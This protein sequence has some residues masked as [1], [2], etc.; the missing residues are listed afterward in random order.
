MKASH[1]IKTLISVG[2]MLCA[3]TGCAKFGEDSQSADIGIDES[4][5]ISEE[6]DPEVIYDLQEEDP[7]RFYETEI[8]SKVEVVKTYKTLDKNHSE[9]M[10]GIDN[11]CIYLETTTPGGPVSIFSVDRTDYSTREKILTY[12]WQYMI[13]ENCPAICG[14]YLVFPLGGSGGGNTFWAH[15]GKNGEEGKCILIKYASEFD[16]A[17]SAELSDTEPVFMCKH[18]EKTD[19][20]IYKYKI[21]DDLAQPIYSE[22][23]SERADDSVPLIA[24]CGGQIYLIYRSDDMTVQIKILDPDG[25]LAGVDTVQLPVSPE[26]Q[27]WNFFVTENHYLIN[28]TSAY[29]YGAVNKNVMVDRKTGKIYSNFGEEGIGT[30]LNNALIDGRYIITVKSTFKYDYPI[31]YVFDDLTGEFHVMKFLD[32]SGKKINRAYA[33]C[34]GDVMFWINEED[35]GASLVLFEDIIS[36]I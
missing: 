30:K 13:G 6:S 7:V 12:N 21:D 24:C 29:N 32:L 36:L 23:L 11:D 15:F 22:H 9:F 5:V 28:Y 10:M 18:H 26:L 20:E 31:L 1:F 35:G 19:I 14:G 17:V 25:K 34:K 27:L 16:Q 33:D 8:K 4:S 2:I 3:V